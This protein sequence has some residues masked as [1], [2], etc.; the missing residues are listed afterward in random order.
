[1]GHGTRG[2]GASEASERGRGDRRK[3]CGDSQAVSE[4]SVS[5]A[6][7][8]PAVCARATEKDFPYTRKETESAKQHR[9]P[10]NRGAETPQHCGAFLKDP[11][12]STLPS[13]G[14]VTDSSYTRRTV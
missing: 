9:S 11:P 12:E 4:K 8:D 7:G 3:G 5:A 10:K 13:S 2:G 6:R 1:M 14:E